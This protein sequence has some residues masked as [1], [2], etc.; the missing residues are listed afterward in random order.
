MKTEPAYSFLTGQSDTP[1]CELGWRSVGV[2]ELTAL[3]SLDAERWRSWVQAAD[4]LL[5]NGGDALYLAHW[6]RESGLLDLLP[7]LTEAVWVGLSGGSMVMA[8][9]IGEEFV[10]WRP[11]GSDDTAPVDDSALGVV[12]FAMFPHVGHPALPS[13]TMD[14]AE[15][16][17][18]KLGTPA[19]AVD[20][21]TAI[22]VVDG[23]VE[24]VSEGQWRR[25]DV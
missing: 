23:E 19:Y 16:W 24:V 8:P 22:V 14:A 3:P 13:N 7:S 10:G 1:M 25:F 18:A 15:R 9:R 11:P 21:D 20:D 6:M 2:L 4:F 17:A 12:D 5:V